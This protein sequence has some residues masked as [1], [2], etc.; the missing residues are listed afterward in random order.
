MTRTA[1]II[2]T[3]LSI[4]ACEALAA[5]YNVGTIAIGIPGRAPRR[6]AR[7]SRAPI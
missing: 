2:A 5:D 6:K 7:R 1:F 3:A 4:W